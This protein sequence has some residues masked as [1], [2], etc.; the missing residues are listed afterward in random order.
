MVAAVPA[1]A[2]KAVVDAANV[3]APVSVP[4]SDVWIAMLAHCAGSRARNQ[5]GSAPGN[6]AAISRT[7]PSPATTNRAINHAR[8]DSVFENRV[9]RAAKLLAAM[10][11][12]NP[13][14]SGCNGSDMLKASAITTSNAALSSANSI[15][16]QN[17]PTVAATMMATPIRPNVRIAPPAIVTE[18]G[19]CESINIIE[20]GAAIPNN[21]AANQA[22][23]FLLCNVV[24][25][26]ALMGTTQAQ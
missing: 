21:S 19:D 4:V 8:R 13:V 23:T 17:A 24:E 14:E 1:R 6:A 20:A 7:E 9:P 11:I 2:I 12:A 10:T 25:A 16:T 22:E 3:P 18:V 5:S 26:V 15:P